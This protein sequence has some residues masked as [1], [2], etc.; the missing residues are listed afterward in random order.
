MIGL[1]AF[2]RIARN[3]HGDLVEAALVFACDEYPDLDANVYI[4]QVQLLCEGFDI[5][6]AG[7]TDPHSLLD[8]LADFFFRDLDFRGN[9]LDYYDA[10][11]SYLNDVVDRR[12]GIP[13]SLSVL[14]RAVAASAGIEL[15][16]VNFPGH[17]LLAWQASPQRRVY[18][19][20]F[21]EGRQFEWRECQKRLGERAETSELEESD[22]PAMSHREI[23]LRMLRNLKGI[24]SRGDFERCMRVQKRIARLSPD[25]RD[26]QRDLGILYYHAGKPA[27]A[28]RE[29]EKLVRKHP[30]C[31]EQE[32]VREYLTLATRAAIALN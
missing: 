27:L 9:D 13:I 15:Q 21:H 3:L 8:R 31:R 19:D 22:F 7:E 20:V 23:L 10:R 18:V 26:E 6:R 29:L 24:Y 30:D 28:M 11:N 16:G 17:F 25:D 14:Y 32:P 4:E 2:E 1:D 5:F 12:L